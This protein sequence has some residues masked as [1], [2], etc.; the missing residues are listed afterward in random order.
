M[1]KQ[2][3]WHVRHAFLYISQPSLRD[4]N[5]KVPDFTFCRRQEHKTT[6]VSFSSFSPRIFTQSF[7]IQLPR[8]L[9]IFDELK[10]PEPIYLRV[11][12][13]FESRSSEEMI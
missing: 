11:G 6:A 2:Q 13:V 1:A 7:R 5:E 9:P 4:Y 12:Y 3:L 8:H 10:W